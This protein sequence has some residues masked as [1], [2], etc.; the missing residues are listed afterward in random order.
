[1]WPD[2]SRRRAS[3]DKSISR[4][5]LNPTK[6]LT[7]AFSSNDD[8]N[9]WMF[10]RSGLTILL[11]GFLVAWY[12]IDKK[13]ITLQQSPVASSETALQPTTSD[14]PNQNSLIPDEWKVFREEMR[15]FVDEIGLEK[16][17]FIESAPHEMVISLKDTVPFD[18]GKSDLRQ[19]AV[20]VLEKVVTMVSSHPGLSLEISGYTDNIPI[21]TSKFPANWGL[22]A[23]RASRVARYVIENGV[24]PSR[25]SVRGYANHRQRLPNP[26]VDDRSST[27]RVEIRLYRGDD[28]NPIP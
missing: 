20:P 1:M 7:R 16:E 22:S 6:A 21:L 10:T 8:A 9:W 4:I 27:R 14:A 17:V 13:D 25:I 24:D 11:L 23:A 3:H 12:V 18:S 15:R 5:D 19:R 26:S 28:Q 2:L